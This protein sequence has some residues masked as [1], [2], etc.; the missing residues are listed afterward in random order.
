MQ[1]SRLTEIILH[2]ETVE[3]YEFYRVEEDLAR[4]TLLHLAAEQNFLRVAQI[5]VERYP[6]LVYIG[7]KKV[8][9]ERVY[10]PVE[11]ALISY[12][13]EVAALLISHMKAD[14]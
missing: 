5:L 1:I 12:K 8:G 10:L 4:P 11:K 7:T 14:R 13:D 6:S 9:G 3:D 2:R